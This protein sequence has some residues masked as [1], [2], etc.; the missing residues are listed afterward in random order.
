MILLYHGASYKKK[1]NAVELVGQ[2]RL[3]NFLQILQEKWTGRD[4][5]KHHNYCVLQAIENITTSLEIDSVRSRKSRTAL[6][7]S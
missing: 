4:L 3:T 6:A 2:Y 7:V 1:T 5:R